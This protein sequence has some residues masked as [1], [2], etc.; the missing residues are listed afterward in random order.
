MRCE[1]ERYDMGSAV[2]ACVCGGVARGGRGKGR[3]QNG[4]ADDVA[5]FYLERSQ[6]RC[7]ADWLISF[8]FFKRELDEIS[9]NLIATPMKNENVPPKFT[10]SCP[11]GGFL[12]QKYP[13]FEKGKNP[14]ALFVA[15]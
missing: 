7:A 2:G 15:C 9:T 14:A 13:A 12:V 11:T 5:F 4:H 1:R 3:S 10:V 8:F 6:A